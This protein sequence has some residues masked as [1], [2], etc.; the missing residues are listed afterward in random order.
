MSKLYPTDVGIVDTDIELHTKLAT[1][2]LS[3]DI[4]NIATYLIN[5]EDLCK[6]ETVTHKHINQYKLIPK[7]TYYKKARNKAT[8][9]SAKARSQGKKGLLI[10]M[11]SYKRERSELSTHSTHL[12]H[13]P[14]PTD[15]LEIKDS[16]VQ[17]LQSF[18]GTVGS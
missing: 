18:L 12:S 13:Y 14:I 6:I 10:D 4:E 5:E 7:D 15:S 3:E 17:S 16:T 8:I 11:N 9:A 2:T 1:N